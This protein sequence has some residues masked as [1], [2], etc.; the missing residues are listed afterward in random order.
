M[1][2]DHRFGGEWTEDK[3]S[4]LWKYLHAYTTIFT[5]NKWAAR[6][7]TTYV[8]AFAGTGYR[9]RQGRQGNLIFP[10]S[11]MRR[12]G[13]SGMAAP[14]LPSKPTLHSSNTFLSITTPPT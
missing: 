5:K 12:P 4:R 7:T 6:L 8:D 9:L 11:T 3:L 2:S 1:F 10:C 14:A 13:I